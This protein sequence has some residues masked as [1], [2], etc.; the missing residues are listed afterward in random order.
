MFKGMFDMLADQ[1]LDTEE[2]KKKFIDG[3]KN[4]KDIYELVIDTSL[5]NKIDKISGLPKLFLTI[6]GKWAEANYII[7]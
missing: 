7:S 5:C 1:T 4:S 2:K 3:V 6:M